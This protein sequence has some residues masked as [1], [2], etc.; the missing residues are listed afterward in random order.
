MLTSDT[1]AGPNV[2]NL[3]RCCSDIF[4]RAT[5]LFIVL[6]PWAGWGPSLTAECLSVHQY[7]RGAAHILGLVLLTQRG[8][9]CRQAAAML[10]MRGMMLTNAVRK[11]P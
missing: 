7:R 5:S 8:S 11:C 9:A 3:G 10:R 6:A 1:F 4:T 2:L